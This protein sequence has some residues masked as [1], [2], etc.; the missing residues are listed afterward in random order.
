MW[1]DMV[2]DRVQSSET[3]MSLSGIGWK[4]SGSM[5]RSRRAG[6]ACAGTSL[7]MRPG[8]IESSADGNTMSSGG[9]R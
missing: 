9:Y 5:P 3:R 4:L 1:V 7:S 2:N 6:R 8:R